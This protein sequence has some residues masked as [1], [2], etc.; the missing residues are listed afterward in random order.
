MKK[1]KNLLKEIAR[2]P[3]NGLVKLDP[4]KFQLSEYWSRRISGEHR[5]VYQIVHQNVVVIT[6]RY[7]Y[8]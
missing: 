8:E 6:C 2:D 3:F 5:L 1:V 4:L 7:Q